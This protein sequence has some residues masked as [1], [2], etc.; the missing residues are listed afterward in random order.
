MRIIQAKTNS[1]SERKRWADSYFVRTEV[2]SQLLTK[3]DM[4]TKD[5]SH[6][7]KR[8][9]IMKNTRSLQKILR[10]IHDKMNPSSEQDNKDRL[11]NI[12][13]GKLSKQETSEFLSNANKI[14]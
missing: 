8:N 9:R 7:L 14:G 13:T 1:I 2:F 12:S 10:S 5:V 4:M 6:D 3:L 11:F